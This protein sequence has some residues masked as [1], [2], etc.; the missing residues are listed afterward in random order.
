MFEKKQVWWIECCTGCSC[1][2]NENFDF[3][4]YLNEEEGTIIQKNGWKEVF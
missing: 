1:C 3:G 4:F 2:A